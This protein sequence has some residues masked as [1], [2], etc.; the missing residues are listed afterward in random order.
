M[1][2]LSRLAD[3]PELFSVMSASA[4]TVITDDVDAD[5]IASVDLPLIR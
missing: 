5:G 2:F 1:T 3:K 4:L